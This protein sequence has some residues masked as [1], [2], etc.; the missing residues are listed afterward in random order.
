MYQ[1]YIDGGIVANN[2]SMCALAQAKA[3]GVSLDEIVLLSVGTGLNLRCLTQQDADWGWMQWVFQIRPLQNPPYES[4]LI[5]AMLEGSV[6]LADYQC[7]QLLGD[8]YRRLDPELPQIIPLDA[9]D[10]IPL[11]IN[12]AEDTE[13]DE[14]ITWLSIQFK[15]KDLLTTPSD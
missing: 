6:G 13:I 10:Q 5:D 3:E 8:N 1:G 7:Q 15:G 11:L 9:V 14:I 12:T 2:P 4:P